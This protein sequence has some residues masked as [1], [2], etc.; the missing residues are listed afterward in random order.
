MAELKREL[1]M[2]GLTLTG[3]KTDLVERLQ[4][5]MLEG[6]V[7]D[8]NALLDDNDDV[9]DV[10][11]ITASME[12]PHFPNL[13]A[14]FK[15]DDELEEETKLY[16]NSSGADEDVLLKLPD[17][18]KSSAKAALVPI[19]TESGEVQPTK[20]ILKRKSTSLIEATPVASEQT[21]VTTA[22]TTTTTSDVKR[23]KIE[24]I[25]MTDESNQSNG[26]S[27][28]DA[29]GKTVKVSQLS[30]KERMEMRAKKFG[31]APSA[32]SLKAAR[33]ERFGAAAQAPEADKATPETDKAAS[34]AKKAAEPIA[35]VITA[36]D[37]GAL[38]KR[39]ERFGYSVAK[40]MV[41]MENKEK[42]LKRQ[43]RF[44]NA[45]GAST[46][47]STTPVTVTTSDNDDRLKARIERF[48]ATA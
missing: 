1:K 14:K 25:V 43:E 44:G 48:K 20:V 23:A 29:D 34:P 36:P 32:D 39:A 47:S 26:A 13:L 24:P 8:E 37:V 12:N 33:A 15:Q 3:N 18:S 38:K 19:T 45:E 28:I 11:K 6:D 9:L 30:V 2:R 16:L 41:T 22:T 7:F 21:T 27:T 46:G 17:T 40:T 10:S 42:L 31:A 35:K 4:S 5:A